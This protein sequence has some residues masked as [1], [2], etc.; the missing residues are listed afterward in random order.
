[1][2]VRLTPAGLELVDT[3]AE[4]HLDT[5]RRILAALSS[6]QQEDLTRHLR[7]LLLGLDDRPPTE[8]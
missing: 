3:V 4:G 2:V 7:S 1:V 6:R 8:A 5:E